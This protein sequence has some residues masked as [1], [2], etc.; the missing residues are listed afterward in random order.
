LLQIA[1]KNE[2]NTADALK[3][4]DLLRRDTLSGVSRQLYSPAA[5]DIA[6]Q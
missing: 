5:S 3:N 4:P 2:E 1:R 6:S